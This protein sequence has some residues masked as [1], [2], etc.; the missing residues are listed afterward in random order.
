[1]RWRLCLL[2]VLVLLETSASLAATRWIFEKKMVW[3][4]FRNPD[5]TAI[6]G[7]F[8]ITN[9]SILIDFRDESTHRQFMQ[10]TGERYANSVPLQQ[11]ASEN[12]YAYMWYDEQSYSGLGRNLADWTEIFMQI[13]A[14][15]YL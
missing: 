14:M 2:V 7:G 12:H 15:D 13:H 9:S 3:G 10:I 8:A 1:M 5:P 11:R 6:I 4:S